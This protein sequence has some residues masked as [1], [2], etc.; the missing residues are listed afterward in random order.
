MLKAHLEATFLMVF[1]GMM[2]QDL[3]HHPEAYK[4]RMFAGIMQY[5]RHRPTGVADLMLHSTDCVEHA[6]T[7]RY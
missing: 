3:L 5:P 4:L 7:S 6:A 2:H 1:L